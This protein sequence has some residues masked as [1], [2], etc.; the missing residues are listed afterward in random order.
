MI[1]S[2]SIDL[3]EKVIKHHEKGNSIKA[4]AE[5]FE[6]G[7]TTVSEWIKLKKETGELEKRPLN[8]THKKIEPKKLKAYVKENPDHFQ[9]EIAK[10][11]DCTQQAVF[12]ALKRLGITRKKNDNLS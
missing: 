11:F 9:K 10:A 7:T 4:T 6:I 8:R 2:Y 3:R 5:L 1:M 12:L